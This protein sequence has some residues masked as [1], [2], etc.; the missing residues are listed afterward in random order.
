MS[1]TPSLFE[2]LEV[3]QTGAELLAVIDAYLARS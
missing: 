3:A 1:S 2:Q